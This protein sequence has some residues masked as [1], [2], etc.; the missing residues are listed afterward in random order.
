MKKFISYKRSWFSLL[1]PISLA[2]LY[3]FS[4]HPDWAEWYC[5]TLYPVFSLPINQISSLFP[6]SLMEC[7]LA[8]LIVLLPVLLIRLIIQVFRNKKERK[9]RLLRALA[10]LLC[11]IGI[12]AFSY[13]LNCGINY[14]RYPFAQVTG[15]AVR[16]SSA[17]ELKALCTELAKQANL[18]RVGIETDDQ[19]VT[20]LSDRKNA[21]ETARITMNS[22]EKLYP[23]LKSGYGKPKPVMASRVMSYLNITGIY[24]PFTVESNINMDA[25]AYNIPVTMLHEL[26]HVR[27][28][29]REDEANFIAYLACRN[30]NSQAFA[31]SGTMLAFLYANNSLYSADES[32]GRETYALLNDEARKDLAANQAYWKRFEGPVADVASKA[33]DTYLKANRQEDG[34]KSYGRMVDLLLA[35]YRQRHGLD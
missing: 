32:A 30:S 3:L 11:A 10:T 5:V 14:S 12:V 29:M 9:E 15:L 13:T 1:L 23:T 20:V 18:E 2:S 22:M 25:P 34:V 6:F 21:A 24:F 19:G 31:Y 16:P 28:Y 4:L 8:I 7:L 35:D 33:N 17:D 27:G 26:S